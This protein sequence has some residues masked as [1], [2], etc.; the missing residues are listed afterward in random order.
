MNR[1]DYPKWRLEK[2]KGFFWIY[3]KKAN[4]YYHLFQTKSC[5]QCKWKDAC[6]LVGNFLSSTKRHYCSE[7]K[8]E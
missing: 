6:N 5:K 7:F 3:D 8:K 1:A 2:P 4:E